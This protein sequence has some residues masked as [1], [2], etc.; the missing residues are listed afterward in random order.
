MCAEIY[1]HGQ[2]LGTHSFL[3]R[4]GFVEPDEYAE[5]KEKYFLPG[6]ETGTAATVLSSLGASVKMD[7][8]HIGTEVAPLLKSF[9]ADKSVDLSSIYFDPDYVGLMDYVVIAGLVR[10]PMGFFQTLYASGIKRW[11]DPKEQDIVEAKVV[12]IDPYFMEATQMTAELCVKHGKPFVTI[13]SR[14]DSYLHQHCA[15]NVV[16][17][18]CTADY[19]KEGKTMEEIFKLL[20]ETTDGLVIITSGEKDMLYGRKGEEM[21]RMK[22][23]PV[24]VRSTLGAGDTFKAGCLYALLRG[25]SDAEIVRFA[26]ACSAIAISRF[27]LPLNPPTMEEVKALIG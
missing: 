9:Y 5:I 18:E 23:I 20:T 7:G 3:L 1:L 6:G 22:P 24:E 8:T 16:S 15:I 11:N 25:M 14:H 19:I 4:D 21:K 13:D 26:S 27:P 12:G 2:I 10:S 17:K